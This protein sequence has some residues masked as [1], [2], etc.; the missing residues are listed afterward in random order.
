MML[1]TNLS[2]IVGAALSAAFALADGVQT[3]AYVMNRG[4]ID[5]EG[6]YTGPHVAPSDEV[7]VGWDIRKTT[8]CPGWNSRVWTG[9]DGFHVTEAKMPTTLPASSEWRSYQIPTTIP[10]LAPAGELTLEIVGAYQ[11]GK[12]E[13]HPFRL[14]PVAFVVEP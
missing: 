14:G 3:I 13:E 5:G 10:E 1:N 9:A 7:V 2:L 4:M 6:S 12:G 11:C 8:D